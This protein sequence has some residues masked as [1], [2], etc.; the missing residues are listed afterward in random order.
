[1]ESQ[2]CGPVGFAS[3]DGWVSEEDR[4][5]WKDRRTTSTEKDRVRSNGIIHCSARKGT[6]TR[7]LPRCSL[8]KHDRF[9]FQGEP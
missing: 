6:S 4:F 2:P 9:G 1:M 3:R 5:E 7:V 8:D